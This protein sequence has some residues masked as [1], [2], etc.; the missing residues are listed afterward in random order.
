M[1]RL[2][3]VAKMTDIVPEIVAKEQIGAE[4]GV[5]LENTVSE[6]LAEGIVVEITVEI[7]TEKEIMAEIVL[8]SVAHITVEKKQLPRRFWRRRRL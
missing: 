1:R 2:W 6:I 8:E 7:M 4:M 3:V 5:I